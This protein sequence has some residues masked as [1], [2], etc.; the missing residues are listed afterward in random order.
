LY[1]ASPLG[2]KIPSHY[3]GCCLPLV[4]LVSFFAAY[5]F[6]LVCSQRKHHPPTFLRQVSLQKEGS[7]TPIYSLIFN[8]GNLLK[9]VKEVSRVKAELVKKNLLASLFVQ[10]PLSRLKIH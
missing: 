1:K 9:W 2:R 8:S 7:Y 5:L 4:N 6:F 10:T 3:S